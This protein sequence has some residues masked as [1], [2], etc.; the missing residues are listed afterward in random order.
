MRGRNA[1]GVILAKSDTI[2]S[3]IY[4]ETLKRKLLRVIENKSVES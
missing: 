1:K 4:C 3:E 2:T